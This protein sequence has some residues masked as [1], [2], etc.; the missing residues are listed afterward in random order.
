MWAR[1]ELGWEVVG[2]N[3]TSGTGRGEQGVDTDGA[4]IHR[5]LIGNC[6]SVKEKGASCLHVL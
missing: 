4:A 5:E 3:G 2:K 6:E 1:K